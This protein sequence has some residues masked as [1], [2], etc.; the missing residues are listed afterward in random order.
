MG[1]TGEVAIVPTNYTEMISFTHSLIHSC[2]HAF[3]DSLITS[4]LNGLDLV[5]YIQE[6]A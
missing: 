4:A 6:I 2:M 3:F 5:G 1:D